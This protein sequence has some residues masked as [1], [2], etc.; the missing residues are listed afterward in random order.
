MYDK[1]HLGPSLNSFCE[2]QEVKYMNIHNTLSLSLSLM[3]ALWCVTIYF[4]CIVQLF[5]K[6]FQENIYFTQLILSLIIPNTFT[7]LVNLL[8]RTLFFINSFVFDIILIFLN[9]TVSKSSDNLNCSE[10]LGILLTLNSKF[11]FHYRN[12]HHFINISS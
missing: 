10:A 1:Y 8:Y 9:V 2:H 7:I 3:S 11:M 4:P 6:I 12:I 5:C